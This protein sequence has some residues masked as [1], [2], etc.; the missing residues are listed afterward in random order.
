MNQK[1]HLSLIWELL[2]GTIGTL[3][4][5]SLFLFISFTYVMRTMIR[6]VTINSVEQAMD[7]L[8]G[9]ISSILGEYND[10][11]INLAHVVPSLENRG[12]IRSVVK[13]MGRDMMDETLLYYATYEQIWE[14]GTLI[15]HTGWEAPGDFDMQS[16][17]WHKNAVNNRNKICYTE[18]FTDVNTG[19]IIVTISYNVLD[20]SGKII[21]VAAADIVLDALSQAV[22]NINLSDNSRIYIVSS[23][24]RFI[25]NDDFS[26]IMNKSYL[27]T[28]E[29]KTV[30]KADYLSG[31]ERTFT[32]G[33]K[34]YGVRPVSGTDWYIVTEGPSSDFSGAYISLLGF[35]MV[36][37]AVI[38]AVLILMDVVLSKRVAKHFRVIVE[39]CEYIAQ[40][41]FTKVYPDFFTKEASLLAKGFNTFSKSIGS[42]VGTIRESSASIQQVSEQ[43]ASNTQ[44]INDS[45]STTENAIAGMN[46]TI[47]KQALAITSV[48]E[49]VTQVVQKTKNLDSEIDNQNKLIISS[50]ENI[51]SMMKQFFG[52][53][54]TAE[55]MTS[56]V[57]SIVKSSASSTDA[58]KKSVAQIQEVQAESGALLEMNTVISSVASQTN[59]LAMNAAIEAAHAGESGKGFAV[60]ADEIRKLAETTS[61][62]AKNSSAS[63]RSIQEKIDDISASSLDV[64]KSFGL[65]IGEIQNFETA[66]TSLSQTV[67]REGK[68][69]EEILESLTDIKK[70]CSNVKESASVI[71]E[72]TARVEENFV[73]LTSMQS[74]VDNGIRSCDS[75]SKVL[76]ATSK[77]ISEISE[78]AQQSVGKLTDAV[79]AFKV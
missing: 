66:M 4:I 68:R 50:S 20:D 28:L 18:P 13:S 25:T 5:V 42:L 64:E 69:A 19:K 61:K 22:K 56:K 40:G 21:G 55:S 29:E 74:E 7:V 44:E 57:D 38:V 72:G 60:V 76:G 9:K 79:S 59:L 46:G 23:D 63:L 14:G 65:T 41:D 17:L 47:E 71:T 75:A 24:G 54:K 67:S 8:D 2:I 43:L 1:K 35:V 39:G 62:Q 70:S 10:L 6:S 3:F 53:T 15:S 31:K 34:F 26:L 52:I 36:I 48:N 12:Q 37:L 49:A 30:S 11:V 16:R 78:K 27:D 32:E 33:D 45:V 77:N 51:E 73:N 58:L